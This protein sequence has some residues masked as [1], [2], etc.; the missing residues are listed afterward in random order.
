MNLHHRRP[1][2]SQA[3]PIAHARIA[4]GQ[5][6]N[7]R[8]K[9][10]VVIGDVQGKRT[11]DGLRSRVQHLS[12]SQLTFQ[13]RSVEERMYCCSSPAAEKKITKPRY[14]SQIRERYEVS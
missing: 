6:R 4:Q 1:L 14:V 10:M 2:G 9:Q 8:L 5:R 12:R 13:M 3:R 11:A 7:V